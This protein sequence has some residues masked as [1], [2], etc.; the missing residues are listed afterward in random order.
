MGLFVR[1]IE[2]QK[3]EKVNL[4]E[5]GYAKTPS[6]TIT[7]ELRTHSNT[8]SL[9]FIENINLLSN[10]I[11][12]IA[13]M[14]NKITRLDIIIL[15]ADEITSK[16]L[17]IV[18][19]PQNGFS[20]FDDFNNFHYDIVEMDYEKLGVFSDLVISNIENK[21]KC[22]RYNKGDIGKILNEG[23][24]NGFFNL[25]EIQI[26]LKKELEKLI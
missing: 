7:S 4:S 25:D 9:W 16:D 3:W 5:L 11:L 21:T 1:M 13:L 12:A 14:R 10:A 24:Q 19:S 15:D 17:K 8:L 20:P 26:S 2:R 18:H 6:D 23:Y 22:F